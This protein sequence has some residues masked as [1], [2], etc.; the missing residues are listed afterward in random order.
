MSFRGGG[1]GPATGANRGGNF[2]RGGEYG[3]AVELHEKS[4]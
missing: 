3:N 1:R 4:Y 2:S